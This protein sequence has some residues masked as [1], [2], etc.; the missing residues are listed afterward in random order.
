MLILRLIL[1]MVRRGG[2]D[3]Q[4]VGGRAEESMARMRVVAAVVIAVS[5]AVSAGRARADDGPGG[6]GD[7]ADARLRRLEAALAEQRAETDRLRR[8]FDTY[9]REHPS[10]T[11]L[12]ADEIQSAVSSYLS[13]AP[14]GGVELA[15]TSGGRGVRWGGYFHWLFQD[16]STEVSQFD[17]LR[18]VLAADADITDHIDFSME[19]EI[20]HGG[21]SDEN[22]GEI[23][24]EKAEVGF[25]CGDALNPKVGWLL[26]PFGRYNKYHDDPIN[27]FSDR[28]FTARFLVPTGFGQPGAGVEGAFPFGCGHVFTYDVAVTNGYKDAFT[29][30]EGVREARHEGDENDGKQAWGRFAVQWDARCALDTLETGV[31][32]TWGIYD[33]ADKNEITGFAA[34]ILLRKGPFEAK[35]EY[36][37]YDY[38]RNA[39]DPPGSIEGQ[40]GLWVEGAWHFFPCAWRCARGCVVTETSLFTVAA[41]YQWMDL[42]D[43]VHGAT[44][45]DDLRAFSLGLNYRV[46]ERTVFR[47]DHTWYDA[48]SEADRT[49]W[50]FSVSTYF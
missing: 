2:R 22:E 9:R 20:E 19:L 34:D 14:A 32:G 1:N 23:V 3:S 12:T 41:R 35:G 42:D 27:D 17:L 33:D 31:S 49:Q 10:G 25:H 4:G 24:I 5:A 6:A 37:V 39:G 45:E 29:A 21:I 43:H 8:D 15:P 26:V 50:S 38:E 11:A 13:S 28:P 30:D 16:E 46:T 36:V 7:T 40:S 47:V 18:L 48:A 44:F